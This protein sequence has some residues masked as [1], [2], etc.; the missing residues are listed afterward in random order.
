[1]KPTKLL[2]LLTLGLINPATSATPSHSI[3]EPS[4]SAHKHRQLEINRTQ[5]DYRDGRDVG[6]ATGPSKD[7][8]ADP[9]PRWYK[10]SDKVTGM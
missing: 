6:K 4:T 7:A 9:G 10:C 3:P 5:E 1:M 2:T 8:F